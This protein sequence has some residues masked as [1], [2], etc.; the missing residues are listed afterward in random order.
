ME[1]I[2]IIQKIIDGKFNYDDIKNALIQRRITFDELYATSQIPRETIDSVKLKLKEEIIAQIRREENPNIDDFIGIVISQEEL[3]ELY[4]IIGIEIKERERGEIIR[5]IRND[6][7]PL[8]E[9]KQLYENGFFT[10]D[11]LRDILSEDQFKDI[12]PTTVTINTGNWADLPELKQDRVDVFTFGRVGSGKTMFLA[13][14]LYY[15]KSLGRAKILIEPVIGYEY[16]RALLRVIEEKVF[17]AGTVTEVINYMEVDMNDENEKIHPLT[18]LEMSG[19]LF[20]QTL[21]VAD[22]NQMPIRLQEYFFRNP[23]NKAMFLVTDFLGNHLDEGDNFDF[24]LQ[25]CERSKLF[26]T[27]EMLT[28]VIAKWDASPDQSKQAALHFLETKHK[29]LK[30]RCEELEKKYKFNFYIFTF[31]I[32][33]MNELNTRYKFDSSHVEKIYKVLMNTSIRPPKKPSGW[34]GF[35]GKK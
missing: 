10:K 33:Q 7:L 16:A 27:V 9:V 8:N 2:I 29:E 28:I 14:L 6:S 11:E 17:P 21:L 15:M 20:Q 25:F 32:G 18:F 31:S 35:F 26:D 5:K 23:N 30:V 19:E 1:K 34:R 22:E 12:F 4:G 13:S 3:D 24:F